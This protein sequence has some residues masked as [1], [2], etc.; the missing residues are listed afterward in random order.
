[1]MN[2]EPEMREETKRGDEPRKRNKAVERQQRKR[3]ERKR[4][5][6]L[7]GV[8]PSSNSKHSGPQTSLEK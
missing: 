2:R 8:D 7:Q 5:E 6:L 3:R 4:R 1:M